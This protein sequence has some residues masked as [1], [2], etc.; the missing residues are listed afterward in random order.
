MILLPLR[1]SVGRFGPKLPRFWT[2]DGPK[3]WGE[4]LRWH[5]FFGHSFP[6]S[7]FHEGVLVSPS[8]RRGLGK[9]TALDASVP[10]TS[11]ELANYVGDVCERIAI[12]GVPFNPIKDSQ[13]TQFLYVGHTG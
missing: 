4:P 3:A 1:R 7:R 11:V 8:R 2:E 5:K 13:D 12:I 6:L 10:P 9:G